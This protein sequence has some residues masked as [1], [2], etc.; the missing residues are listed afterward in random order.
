MVT[1]TLQAHISRSLSF[2]GAG[3]REYYAGHT[4]VTSSCARSLLEDAA[5]LYYFATRLDQLLEFGNVDDI[6]DFIFSRCFSSKR[7]EKFEL[8]GRETSATNVL[9]Y[10]DRMV[11]L[12]PGYRQVYDDLSEVVHPNGTGIVFFYAQFVK[13]GTVTFHDGQHQAE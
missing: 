13:E 8:F 10:I 1:T 4:I 7:P 2:I 5:V 3:L 12:N 9:T 11:K 6:D